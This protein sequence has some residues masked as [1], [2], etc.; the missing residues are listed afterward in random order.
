MKEAEARLKQPPLQEERRGE[1]KKGNNDNTH[2]RK[3]E[4]TLQAW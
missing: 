3:Q 1:D 2:G 4:R